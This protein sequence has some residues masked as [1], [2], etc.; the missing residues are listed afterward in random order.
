MVIFQP[1]DWQESD[2]DFKKYDLP[3]VSKICDNINCNYVH[4]NNLRPYTIFQTV[5]VYTNDPDENKIN[6]LIELIKQ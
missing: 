4:E 1:C 5:P 3:E 2:I 6:K